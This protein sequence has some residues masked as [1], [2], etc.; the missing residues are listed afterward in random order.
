MPRVLKTSSSSSAASA[1]SPGSTR[2]RLDTS[3]TSAAERRVR[4]GELGAGDAGADDDEL[5][6]QRVRGRTAGSTSG[7]A[8]RRARPWAASRGVAPVATQHDVGRRAWL[9]GRASRRRRPPA[10]G[11]R[12]GRADHD[13][14]ALALE[15]RPDVRGL[16]GRERL[17]AGVH[18]GE[19]D[20]VARPLG[21]PGRCVGIGVPSEPG[22][23]ARCGSAMVIH[24]AVA[25]SVLEG[26][27][28]GEHG[29]PAQPGALHDGDVGAEPLGARGRPR[30]RPVHRRRRRHG[31]AGGPARRVLTAPYSAVPGALPARGAREPRSMSPMTDLDDP[32]TDPFA[33][34][35]EAAAA[36]RRGHRCRAATTSPSCSARAGAGRRPARRDR[37]RDPLDGRSRASRAAVV[38]PRAARSGRSG[39]SAGPASTPSCSARAPT[40]TRA[41]ACGA[42]CTASARRRRRAHDGRAHQR[43]RRAQPARGARARRCSSA[44]TSTSR[45]RRPSRARRSSTSP[46]CTRRGCAP[47]RTR[48]T[49]PRRGRLRAVPRART[50]RRRPRS[51]WPASWAATSWACRRRSRRSRPGTRGLEVLG[52]SLVTNLA[53]GI[54]PTPLVPRRGARGRAPPARASARC[55][56]RSSGAS[57]HSEEQGKPCG[58]RAAGCA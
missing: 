23:P 28:V 4:T 35:R 2:S 27:D 54:S 21:G 47:S 48:S 12:A 57:K 29:R 55:S 52:V 34:A 26:T 8:R 6:G 30:S 31:C 58:N 42:S 50:T 11:R 14:H 24:S 39:S 53:A 10:A 22:C 15:P 33:V 17:D 41:A 5:L 7:C 46:T 18:G 20:A 3:A 38:G 44:T 36:S 43:L 51:A 45:R 25:M 1:S 37:R 13:P 32:T 9:V 40:C 49:R 19:V 56:P 16:R